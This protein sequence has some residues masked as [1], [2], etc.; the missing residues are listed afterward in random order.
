M[1]NIQPPSPFANQLLIQLVARYRGWPQ[2]YIKDSGSRLPEQHRWMSCS[3]PIQPPQLSGTVTSSS[4]PSDGV[5]SGIAVSGIILSGFTTPNQTA[6]LNGVNGLVFI[7]NLNASVS[8]IGMT[9]QAVSQNL[10]PN[11]GVF[12]QGEN[13][14][15]SNI[16]LVGAGNASTLQVLSL[17]PL[18][19]G[20]NSGVF[21]YT[22]GTSAGDYA[23]NPIGKVRLM[24]GGETVSGSPRNYTLLGERQ[25]CGAPAVLPHRPHK[26][27]IILAMCC[28]KH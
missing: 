3:Q 23:I 21:A 16:G 6:T 20:T 28:Q 2:H 17:I 26:L 15:F 8:A 19:Q 7:P 14:F 10:L 25:Q 4:T 24:L 11:V 1:T 27:L 13:S 18:V 22:P 5:A 12:G 9:G